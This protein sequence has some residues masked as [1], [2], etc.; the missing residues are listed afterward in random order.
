M[1]E[2]ESPLIQR[3]GFLFKQGVFKEFKK[4]MDDGRPVRN[5]KSFNILTFAD[6]LYICRFRPAKNGEK[7]VSIN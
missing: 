6:I 3:D 4:L 1:R 5:H 7:F 2:L